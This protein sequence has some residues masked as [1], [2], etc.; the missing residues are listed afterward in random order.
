MDKHLLARPERVREI[1]PKETQQKKWE[2]KDLTT[3][4]TKNF[5]KKIHTDVIEKMYK[6]VQKIA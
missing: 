4:Y 6:V 3:K 2:K 1:R 5:S